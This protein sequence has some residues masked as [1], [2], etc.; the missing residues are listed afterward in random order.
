MCKEEY[1]SQVNLM[2][3]PPN[4]VTGNMNVEKVQKERIERV[5]A[6][7]EK[8]KTARLGYSPTPI[9]QS[10]IFDMKNGFAWGK[11]AKV[12]RNFD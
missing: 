9:S 10:Y 3:R 7:C 2:H 12:I 8:Y 5:E 1:L 11:H 4:K 6:V